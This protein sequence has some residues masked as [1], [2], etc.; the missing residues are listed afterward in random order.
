M[1]FGIY[2]VD[3]R[4]RLTKALTVEKASENLAKI[5]YMIGNYAGL[6]CLISSQQQN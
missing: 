6:G 2:K 3:T 4:L 1:D 5:R